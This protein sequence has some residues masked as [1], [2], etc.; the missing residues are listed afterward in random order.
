MTYY[1]DINSTEQM[2]DNIVGISIGKLATEY[3]PFA[4]C[5]MVIEWDSWHGR[6]DFWW[7]NAKVNVKNKLPADPFDRD[8]ERNLY[9]YRSCNWSLANLRILLEGFKEPT[10]ETSFANI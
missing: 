8:D 1:Y 3:D 9:I 2:D 10:E 4:D 5:C 6:V 7:T